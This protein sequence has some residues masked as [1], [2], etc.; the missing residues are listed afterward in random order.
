MSGFDFKSVVV[1]E[2]SFDPLTHKKKVSFTFDSH[3]HADEFKDYLISIGELRQANKTQA[4]RQK[5][6]RAV[7]SGLTGIDMERFVK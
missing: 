5:E 7:I 1:T 2:H 6:F 4:E 3:A